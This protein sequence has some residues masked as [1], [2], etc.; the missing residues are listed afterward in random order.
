L[1]SST[2]NTVG[3]F[4]GTFRGLIFFRACG[5]SNVT[6]NKK[7]NPVM[8]ALMVVR[9]TPVETMCSWNRRRSSACAWSGERPKKRVKFFTARMYPVWVCSASLRMLMSSIMRWRNGLI[10]G[11]VVV[12]MGSAPVLGLTSQTNLNTGQTLSVNA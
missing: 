12:V 10:D 11:C 4:C 8:V 6:S 5:R 1:I 3:S 7:R 9:E 2:L